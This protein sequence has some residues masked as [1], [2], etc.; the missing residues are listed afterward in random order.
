MNNIIKRRKCNI[1]NHNINYSIYYLDNMLSYMKDDPTLE[2]FYDMTILN[3]YF[4]KKDIIRNTPNGLDVIDFNDPN[5]IHNELYK[6]TINIYKHNITTGY[7][8][9]IKQLKA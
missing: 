5:A 9:M 3:I 6:N 4:G 7:E 8:R 2:N 1:P